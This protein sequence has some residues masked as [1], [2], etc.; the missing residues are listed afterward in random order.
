MIV[1]IA[2]CLCADA[3]SQ[4]PRLQICHAYLSRSLDSMLLLVFDHLFHLLLIEHAQVFLASV[5]LFDTFLLFCHQLA[6][7]AFNSL[8][9]VPDQLQLFLLNLSL[10]FV[11]LVRGAHRAQHLLV[12]LAEL[13]AHFVLLERLEDVLEVFLVDQTDRAGWI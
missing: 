10:F 7:L 11:F 13:P 6:S 3:D 1:D 12:D 5:E 9:L 8:A 4:R 2:E